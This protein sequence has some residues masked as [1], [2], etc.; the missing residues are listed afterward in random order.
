M[1]FNLYS[2]K[3]LIESFP[4][5]DGVDKKISEICKKTESYKSHNSIHSLNEENSA[6]ASYLILTKVFKE[7]GSSK[8]I[9]HNLIVDK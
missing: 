9:S 4:D 1:T 5:M 8:T 6:Q 3:K 2:E 7:D